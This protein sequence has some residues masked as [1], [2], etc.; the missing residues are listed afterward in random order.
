MSRARQQHV[1]KGHREREDYMRTT[2]R[3]QLV[4]PTLKQEPLV[5]FDSTESV[6][7]RVIEPAGKRT[8]TRRKARPSTFA[9]FFRDHGTEFYLRVVLVPVLAWLFYQVF[10]LNREVGHLDTKVDDLKPVEQ[11]LEHRIDNLE[12]QVRDD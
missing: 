7:G 1:G 4:E 9:S 8:R 2:V 11:R 3:R 5:D 6:S 10:T 12:R